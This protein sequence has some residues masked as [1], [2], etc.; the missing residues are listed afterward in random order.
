MMNRQP[1]LTVPRVCVALLWMIISSYI[2]NLSLTRRIAGLPFVHS[3]STEPGQ[4]LS[5]KAALRSAPSSTMD[6]SL[7]HEIIRDFSVAEAFNPHPAFVN[8]HVQTIGGFFLRETHSHVS[9]APAADAFVHS[10][11]LWAQSLRDVVNS[12]KVKKAFPDRVVWRYRET[13]ETPDGDFFHADSLWVNDESDSQE[14]EGCCSQVPG[15]LDDVE[16]VQRRIAYLTATSKVPTVILLHGLESNSFSTLSQNLARSFHTRG[17]NCICLNFRSCSGVPNRTLGGYHVGFTQDLIHYLQLY[18]S[19]RTESG[20]SLGR[21]YVAGFSLG[22]NVALKFAG[23]HAC[24]ATELYGV[25]G[26][27]ALSVPLDQSKNAAILAQPGGVRRLVYTRNLVTQLQAKG[28]DSL[29]RFANN[30]PDTRLFDYR[31][32][33]AAKTITD[34]DQA[35]IAPIYGFADAQDYYEKNSC[36][37]VT[38]QIRVPTMILNAADDPFLDPSVWP[39][40]KF[41]SKRTESDGMPNAVTVCD[42]SA[43]P[44]KWVRTAHGGHLGFCWHCPPDGLA[45]SSK[46]TGPCPSW[47]SNELARFL[48][49][50]EQGVR[51]RDAGPQARTQCRKPALQGEVEQLRGPPEQN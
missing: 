31:G 2:R 40:D 20:R 34:F 19:R 7:A 38:D 51:T 21:V 49:H 42:H 46:S 3:F 44:I 18:Q 25:V 23:D 37:K 9:P 35:F 22:A 17:F 10:L 29:R 14:T 39:A 16:H 13:V 1:K 27:A 43:S 36:I 50:V 28:R 45:K 6:Q 24:K 15:L 26:V 41:S 5:R 48:A 11:Q 30:D 4:V 32:V 8:E 12:I 47:A 33:L